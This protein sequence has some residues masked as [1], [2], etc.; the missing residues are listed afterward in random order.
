MVSFQSVFVLI[1]SAYH[2]E[3]RDVGLTDEVGFGMAFLLRTKA[4]WKQRS[5]STLITITNWKEN[6]NENA[7]SSFALPLKYIMH[8]T[9]FCC[10]LHSSG[11]FLFTTKLLI[12]IPKCCNM[13]S[14]KVAVASYSLPRRKEQRRTKRKLLLCL[15]TRYTL[16][17]LLYAC[18]HSLA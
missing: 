13:P 5:V 17:W 9:L 2:P 6:W 16:R 15:S 11:A 1:P 12:F 7:F 8:L 3:C 18:W 10:K 4:D 14:T